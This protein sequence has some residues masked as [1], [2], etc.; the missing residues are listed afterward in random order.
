M[1]AFVVACLFSLVAYASAENRFVYV[2]N[3]S[4]P[5]TITAYRINFDGSLTQLTNSPFATGGTG[6]GGAVGGGGPIETMAAVE[7]GRVRYLYAANGGDGTISVLTIDPETGSLQ[8]IAGSPFSAN[9]S[10]GVYS[11]AASPDHRFLFITNQDT[12]EIH[13]FT[14]A[15]DT[16]ALLEIAGS[17]FQ[18]NANLADLKVTANNQFL[19]AAGNSNSAVEVFRIARSGEL[20]EVPGSPFA[21][22]GEVMEVDS[23]CASSRVF[24]VSNTTALVD[25]YSLSAS[26][27]LTPV[28]GSPFQNGASGLGSNSFGLA[29]S[30]DNR[31][32]FT[33]D[34]FTT[35]VTSFSVARNGVLS[36][37]PGSP[38]ATTDWLGGMAVTRKGDF[39]YSIGFA[40][41]NVDGRRIGL[42][43]TLTPVPGTPFVT[44]VLNTE[45]GEINSIVTSPA[46][47]CR[48]LLL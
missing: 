45:D 15:G 21:A 18:A 27:S 4:A 41:G 42:D 16:G 31:F 33:A 26:G 39:L 12:T 5:N 20:S 8:P 10:P 13:V 19:I 38:F 2:N 3:Q 24:A 37:V 47:T 46:P 34:S 22:S 40:T 7:T 25:A 11:L 29:L 17:P 28:P 30:P 1:K 36:Q 23:N 32:L 44:G 35:E 43:G 14:I 9:D 48:D 6:G